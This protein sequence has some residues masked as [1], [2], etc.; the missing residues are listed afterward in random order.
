MKLV[1]LVG[2][3]IKK[4]VTMHGHMKV[5]TIYTKIAFRF[6]CKLILQLPAQNQKYSCKFIVRIKGCKRRFRQNCFTLL[7]SSLMEYSHAICK[8]CSIGTTHRHTALPRLAHGISAHMPTLLI[9]KSEERSVS[10]IQY[11]LVSFGKW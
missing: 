1:H 4:F 6:S 9:C 2:F 5:K 11:C 7:I 10:G 8:M 3:I